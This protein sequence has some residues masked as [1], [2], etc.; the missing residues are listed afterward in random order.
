MN[1]ETAITP[2]RISDSSARNSFTKTY[3]GHIT[4]DW[5][6]VVGP[7]GGFIAAYLLRAA[8]LAVEGNRLARSLTV[9][10][11]A[12]PKISACQIKTQIIRQGKSLTF[13]R[14][15]MWQEDILCASAI[16][17]FSLPYDTRIH[18]PHEKMPAA[19]SFDESPLMPKMLPI[20]NNY[21]MRS[22]FGTQPFTS[23]DKAISG[24][25][26]RLLEPPADFNAEMLAAISDCWPPA[27]FS[28]MSQE[29]FGKSRGMPTIELS[30][31]FVQ[32]EIYPQLKPT[33]PVLARFQARETLGGLFTEDG[34]I[35][36]KNGQ[37]SRACAPACDCSLAPL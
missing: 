7:N 19:L 12:A 8:R 20:H 9:D 22:A 34:D 30:V 18:L 14:A 36:S 23:G 10:Y 15:E 6:I 3:K 32:A 17:S 35:W 1:F 29:Q 27:L 5:V 28:I 24:G 31:Y 4:Q 11:F 13:V 25:W 33:E 37:A 21:E 2:Q 16:A 26:T